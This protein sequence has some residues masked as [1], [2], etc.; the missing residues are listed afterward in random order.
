V[1]IEESMDLVNNRAVDMHE[2]QMISEY[3]SSCNMLALH[4]GMRMIPNGT[5]IP[6]F[7]P[8]SNH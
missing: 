7:F 6:S 8:G 5:A 4:Y 2:Q 1:Q 3:S